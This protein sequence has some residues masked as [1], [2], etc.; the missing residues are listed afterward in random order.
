MGHYAPV[1]PTSSAWMYVDEAVASI[2]DQ[3]KKEA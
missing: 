2:F 3:D 1:D